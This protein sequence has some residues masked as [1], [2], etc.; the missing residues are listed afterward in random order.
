ML[1]NAFFVLFFLP[2]YKVLQRLEELKFFPK[3]LHTCRQP[4]PLVQWY[5]IPQELIEKKTTTT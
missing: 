5:E 4:L 1:K 2:E 3:P